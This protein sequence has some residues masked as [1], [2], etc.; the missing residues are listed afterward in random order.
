[1][2]NLSFPAIAIIV[3]LLTFTTKLEAQQKEVKKAIPVAGASVL[4]SEIEFPVG[5]LRIKPTSGLTTKCIFQFRKDEW[6]PEV[7]YN[8][9]G[10][11]GYLKVTS[12]GGV[13]IDFGDDRHSGYEKEDQSNWGILFPSEVPHDLD[14]EMLAGNAKI[15]LENSRLGDFEF[16]MTA[17]EAEINL[18]KTSVPDVD[19]KA[20]AGEATLD[21]SG[22]WHNDLHADIR[23][24]FGSITIKL[25]SNMGVELDISGILGDVDAPRMRKEGNTYYNKA[26]GETPHTLY[27][28]VNGGIGDISVE[29]MDD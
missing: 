3:F 10:D 11:E 16:S 12:E 24:G 27:L 4:H 17:G 20:L 5:N 19:F 26:F 14:I 22:L 9:E 7:Y 13:D 1:M 21:F 29:W 2:K 23:G 6:E 8:K 15:D 18:R 28:D 25:P